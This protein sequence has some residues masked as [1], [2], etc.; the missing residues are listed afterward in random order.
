[1]LGGDPLDA[2]GGEELHG[3]QGILRPRVASRPEDPLTHPIVAEELAL[4]EHV[5]RTLARTGTPPTASE[6]EIVRE[7][8][9]I[10]ELL[11]S[12][13]ETKDRPLL[14]DEWSRYQ[15]L[16]AQLRRG[17]E[18]RAGVDLDSPYF[19]HLRLRDE[20]GE[21]DLCLGKATRIEE[22]LRIVDWR[23]A[24]ISRVF[25][26]YQQGDE[27]E[28][29]MGGRLHTG[30]VV[31]RRSVGIRHARLERVDAPEG[32]FV[33]KPGEPPSFVQVE[34]TPHRLAGGEGVAVRV[35]GA[36]RGAKRRLG[37]DLAG[38]RRRAD[39]RLPE[40][41]ALIDPA[42][43]E[44][45][46]RPRSGVAVV[47]GS[48]GSGKTTVALHRIAWLAYD[49]RRIDS[50][51]TL[52]VTFSPALREYV[53]GVLP[54]LGVTRARIETFADWAHALRRRL[55]PALPAEL[56]D[57]TPAHARRLKL[58]PRLGEALAERVRR[59]PG[60]N[61]AEQAIDDWASALTDRAR[62]EA[63][64][65]EPAPGAL[66][67]GELS[68]AL[69]W[70]R[71]RIAEIGA[72][73]E[74]EVGEEAALDP[75]DEA[76]LL[77]AWQ[78]R[79]G[80]LPARGSG[81]GAP[82][83]YHHL[84]VDEVQDFAPLELTVLLDCTDAE[85]SVTLA[86]DLAQQVAGDAAFASFEEL[87]PQLGLHDAEVTTLETSYR[88]TAQIMGFA[89]ALLGDQPQ[90]GRAPRTTRSGPPVELF[91]FADA[92]ACVA[93]LADALRDLAR[94]EPLASVA[95]LAG[96]QASAALY[97]EG[98]AR[99]EVPRLWRVERHE[100][101][102]APGIEVAEI[103][104]AKGLEFDYVV[105]LDVDDE[106]F[107]STALA[108]RLLHVGATRAVHQLWVTSVGGTAAIALA[109]ARASDRLPA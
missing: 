47:R 87:L 76:L 10:R 44:L 93:F 35:H 71:A 92:G 8:A 97:H 90:A 83:R 16:L 64:F 57:D 80:P 91:E 74:G 42:Q 99:A 95:L 53:A 45:I 20:R 36:V 18:G 43:F 89:R 103:E 82:L 66:R 77:R 7:L 105:L 19:A 13:E 26:R 75:E 27:Y 34:S 39:K 63:L 56:R 23:N 78:L 30:V 49:D 81:P 41:A 11:V 96:S 12:G 106:S 17:R 31:A 100:F 54:E 48:A 60:E 40:I 109:A 15:A 50:P 4:L 98:L 73:F 5:L 86:G 46:A 68:R 59:V 94:A 85:R 65:R 104:Q 79:V 32:S 108:R 52:F 33:R 55:F 24:P 9:R 102:F 101:R 3:R 62:L 88:S 28:E 84:A 29:T 58:H 72:A 38:G 14:E 2:L 6:A 107:P 67:P 21:R 69:D 51:A 61:T 25:Y 22:G 37:T 70:C 1:V